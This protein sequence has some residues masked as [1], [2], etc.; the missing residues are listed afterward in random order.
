[1]GL[2]V[3]G[4]AE[5]TS[6][7]SVLCDSPQVIF[8]VGVVS[9]ELTAALI[10]LA[11]ARL[12]SALVSAIGGGI[13]SEGRKC[14]VT[15]FT[16][17]EN[18]V[19]EEIVDLMASV[20]GLESHRA[21]RL[22]VIRYSQGGEYKAHFDGYDL[23]SERGRQCTSRRGQRTHTSILY[24]NDDFRGGATQ[25]PRLSLE[26]LPRDGAVLSFE[27]C[28]H[29]SSVRHENSLHVGSPVESGEKWIATLWF[30]ER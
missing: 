1:M 2:Q 19:I 15:W 5:S 26:I 16:H 9:K 12:Q 30:R 23:D 28:V 20:S 10:A 24:L 17:S 29:E 22:Q 21:E 18:A 13:V 11:K 3:E 8:A 6:L 7:T 25:F 14:E 4:T 27:N